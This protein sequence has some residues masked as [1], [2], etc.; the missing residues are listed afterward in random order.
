M[1]NGW[2]RSDQASATTWR[3]KQSLAVHQ[4]QIFT[5]AFDPCEEVASAAQQCASA[6]LSTI[7]TNLHP[8]R[9]LTGVG[10]TDLRPVKNQ[11]RPRQRT[12]ISLLTPRTPFT[13]RAIWAAR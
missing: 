1:Q 13:S 9:H 5:V 4:S 2:V 12:A 7:R 10:V 11:P 3:F 8:D 6:L